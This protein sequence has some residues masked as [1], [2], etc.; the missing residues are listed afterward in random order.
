M[1][2]S[3]FSLLC[4]WWTCV[5]RA[6][7]TV[8]LRTSQIWLPEEQSGAEHLALR[9]CW[10]A[11]SRSSSLPPPPSCSTSWNSTNDDPTNL[12]NPVGMVF[13]NRT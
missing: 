7:E 10:G 3:V 6:W 5:A 8:S 4:A 12:I 11:S 1:G 13:C 2:L 9:S